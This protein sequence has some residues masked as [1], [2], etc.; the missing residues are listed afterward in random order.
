MKVGII[1]AGFG[2][3]AAAYRLI[4]SGYEV[5]VLESEGNPGGLAIGY[6][7]PEWEWTLERHYHHWFT[8]DTAV[9]NLAAEIGH[10]VIFMR[11]KTSTFINGKV[12]QLDSP[13]SLL[14]F[15]ELPFL[16]RLKTGLVLGYL[17]YT[18]GWEKLESITSESFIKK[19]MGEKSWKVL[20]RPL[21]EK[22]F[23]HYASQIPASWFWARI[24]KRS[25]SLGYPKGGFLPF[26]VTLCDAIKKNGGKIYYDTKIEKITKQGKKIV[27]K[28][29]RGN[30][31][32]D[33]VV[34][35]VPGALFVKIVPDF[36]QEY[37][38]SLIS[39][40]AIGAVNLV[41]SLNKAFLEDGTY[42]LNINNTRFPFLAVVE[43]TNFM[44]KK[45][46]NDEHLVYVGNYLPHDHEYFRKE[47]LDL[48]REFYPFLKTINPKFNKDWVNRAYLFK[49]PFA[50]PII[51]L[52]YS[53]VLPSFETPIEGLYLCNIQQVYPWDRGTNYAVQNGEKVADL[54]L[55]NI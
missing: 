54:I 18:A 50:Q 14:R 29:N 41:L 27:L 2:G 19:Y 42:W 34:A 37:K 40:E 5:T 55:N 53:K 28:T 7:E 46:Y 49:A 51:P 11:P 31:L 44:D 6:K 24:K 45:F 4:K 16:D 8:S 47:P 35:T 48:L 12:Y 38:E 33:K 15:P 21:F 25:S 30:V 1:G 32:F 22:K 13:A 39:F 36:S 17:K 10:E 52:N 9:R 26:A 43:H 20:W 3:L 23:S